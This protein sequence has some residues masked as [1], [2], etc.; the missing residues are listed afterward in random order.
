M[1]QRV[2]IARALARGANVLL[3]DEPF[4][5]LDAIT[6][7]ALHGELSTLWKERGLTVLFVTHNVREAVTLGQRVVLM[8]GRPG[9]IER[10]WNVDAGYPR[11]SASDA[12]HHLEREITESLRLLMDGVSA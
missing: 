6:R 4:S 1:R 10:V 2:A 11:D 7:D 5:A 12:V 9:R 3:M 8:G